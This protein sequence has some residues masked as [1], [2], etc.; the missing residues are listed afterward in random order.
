MVFRSGQSGT[1]ARKGRIWYGRYYLDVPGQEKRRRIAVQLGPTES[2][3]KA[4][5]RRKLRSALEQAGVNSE[6]HL[7]RATQPLKTFA[8]EAEWWKQNKLSLFKPSCQ[9]NMGQH[10][11]KYLLPRFGQMSLS[12]IDERQAQEFVA[13]LNR[14][15]TLQPKSIRNIVGVLKMILGVKVWRD[16]SLSMPEIP[17][18]EQRYFTEDEMRSIVGAA[19]GQ[20]RVMF[21]TLA[22]TGLRC[23]EVFGL[24]VNDLEFE[25][26][27]IRVRRSV[28]K[29][30]EVSVKTKAGYRVVHVDPA[31]AD[32]I[33][34]HLGTRT[35]GRV[36]HTNRMTP[37]S[38]DNVRR[39][40]HGILET[41]GLD[42][43]GLHAFRHGRVSVLRENGVPDDLVREWVGHSSLRTTS[44]YTHFRDDYRR[45]VADG[46]GLLGKGGMES[47]LPFGPNGPHF[48]EDTAKGNAA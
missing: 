35:A 9:E 4:E 33:R 42:R 22:S 8:Q 44:R 43:G 13:F 36:F 5:A 41:L 48:G 16:W 19:K 18:K 32:M 12:T 3:G 37:F 21:A 38:K 26:G 27:R 47:K 23:G 39:K 30:Q 14:K 28:W 45:Q 1:V 10:L 46:L 25:H 6:A 24:H 11:S 29:G 40:L 34:Q 2:M 31:L 17:V 20:W 15:G 7:V